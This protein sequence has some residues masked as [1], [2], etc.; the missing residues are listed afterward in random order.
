MNLVEGKSSWGSDPSPISRRRFLG[1]AG[2]VTASAAVG[3]RRP[4]SPQEAP[5]EPG[6]NDRSDTVPFYGAHQGGITTSPQRAGCFAAFDVTARR[7]A[8]L[9]ELLKRW[10][11]VAAD[12]CAGGHAGGGFSDPDDV[13]HDD[14]VTLGLGP[15]RLTVNFGFG[16]SLFGIGSTDRFG[17]RDRWPMALVEL[18]GFP[19][20]QLDPARCSG[21]LTVHAC[22]DDPQVVFHAVRQ[23]S[24]TA[25]SWASLRWAQVGFN[26]SAATSGTPR[27]LMG[28]KDGMVNPTGA[29]L[30]EFV[31]I[32]ADQD[33]SWMVGGTYVVARRVRILLDRWDAQTLGAQERAIG[34][35]KVSGAPL[36]ASRG[37]DP[38]DLG[39]RR[40]DGSPVIA[41]D[42]HVRLASAQMNWGQMIL[43]RSYSYNDGALIEPSVAT[44]AGAGGL[45]A[46]Q[47]FI[48]YQQNPRLAFIPMYAQ[49]ARRDALRFFTIHTGSVVAAIPPGSPGPGHFVG[50]QLLT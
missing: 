47:F 38:L 45:D 43:R 30:D 1:A 11:T 2:G 24:R 15:A 29:Q 13:E 48:A 44:P 23:L 36:G 16:P 41:L 4:T 39:A 12:L 42:A 40:P 18:P 14:G 3:L 21:D 46:G 19:N 9:A 37:S 32:G 28:F 20:D 49:L 34:R 7:Q 17:L 31:W 27:N 35:H 8:D 50:E 25:R 33:Q 6:G 26:E 5:S 22:A 10:T